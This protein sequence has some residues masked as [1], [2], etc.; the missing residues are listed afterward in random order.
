SP[1]GTTDGIHAPRSA[2]LAEAP[3]RC[4]RGCRPADRDMNAERAPSPRGKNWCPTAIREILRNP[5]YRGERIWNQSRRIK[6]HTGGKRLRLERPESEWVRQTD[7]RWRIVGDELWKAAQSAREGRNARHVRDAAGAIRRTP[8]I[9]GAR[10]KRLL[11]GF[12]ECAECGGSFFAMGSRL[13]Y[14]C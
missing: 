4:P 5:L 1:H 13:I 6:D 9:P 10:H 2:C 7:E 14:G 3:P 11:A 8:I 12:L